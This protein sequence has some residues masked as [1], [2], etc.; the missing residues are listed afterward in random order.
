[1]K[2]ILSVLMALAMTGTTMVWA[3]DG[4]ERLGEWRM[5]QQMLTGQRMAIDHSERFAQLLEEQPTAA[6]PMTEMSMPP[7]APRYRSPILEDRT[8][9]G[10]TK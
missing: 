2:P 3:E 4:G 1:M 9:Y 6:G 8:R 10:S 7:A 5:K